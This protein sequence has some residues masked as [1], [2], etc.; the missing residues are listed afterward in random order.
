MGFMG[1]MAFMICFML[2]INPISPMEQV[3]EGFTQEAGRTDGRVADGFVTA[4]RRALER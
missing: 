2:P 4:L 3:I 1:G